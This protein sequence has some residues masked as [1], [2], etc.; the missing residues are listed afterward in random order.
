[1]ELKELKVLEQKDID[2]VKRLRNIIN[3]G[4]FK[5]KGDA[6]F[7]VS[8]IFSWLNEL[9]EK[10]DGELKQKILDKAKKGAPKIEKIK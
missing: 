4:E 6:I 10:I 5:V 3:S 2:N 1:M 8:S 7:F 9:E